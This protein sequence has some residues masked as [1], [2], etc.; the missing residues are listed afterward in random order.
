MRTIKLLLVSFITFLTLMNV[1]PVSAKPVIKVQHLNVNNML[2][3]KFNSYDIINVA[4]N[5]PNTLSSKTR[6]NFSTSLIL[7]HPIALSDSNSNIAIGVINNSNDFFTSAM[8]FNDKLHQLL[9]YFTTSYNKTIIAPSASSHDS[10]VIRK[11]CNN[12]LSLS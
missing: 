3:N 5:I 2:T 6:N 10:K 12:S 1:S 7:S 11:K 8:V 4:S 9:S